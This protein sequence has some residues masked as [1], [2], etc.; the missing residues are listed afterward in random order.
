MDI[1][2]SFATNKHRFSILFLVVIF[3]L[4]SGKPAEAQQRPRL[5]ARYAKAAL[6]SLFA[7][8]SDSSTPRN[9][10]SGTVEANT[11]RTIDAAGEN[12]VTEKEKSITELLRQVY[13]LRL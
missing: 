9:E 3:A 12:A 4:L 1:H 7:I 8:E 10:D 6:S 13:E 5:S 11:I 2:R